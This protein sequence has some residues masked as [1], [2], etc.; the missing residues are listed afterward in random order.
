MRGFMKYI[1]F[2]LTLFAIY[3]AGVKAHS[4]P[5]RL[6]DSDLAVHGT[7]AQDSLKVNYASTKEDA[8]FRSVLLNEIAHSLC[9]TGNDGVELA[10]L[11]I[12]T[13]EI[14]MEAGSTFTFYTSESA[15]T[16]GLIAGRIDKPSEYTLRSGSSLVYIRADVAGVHREVVQLELKLFRQPVI[17]IADTLKMCENSTKRVSAGLGYNSYTWSTGATNVS[18]TTL[19]APGDYWVTVTKDHGDIICSFTKYFTVQ[20]A[21]A[22]TIKSVI[23]KEWE[24]D[25]NSVEV[26]LSKE[27]IGDYEYAIDGIHYQKENVFTGLTLG[28]YTIYVHETKGCG[29]TSEEVYIFN[30]PKYFTPNGD[31]IN[32][33][34]HIKYAAYEPK[35]AVEVYDRNGKLI[36][37][38]ANNESWD[39]TFKGESLPADDYW[40]VIT[41]A[42]GRKYNGHFSLIR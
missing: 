39:G 19:T 13:Q 5:L 16:D 8:N 21:N 2:I 26:V 32:D 24:E 30:Y 3:G 20:V 33:V 14:S 10:D 41:R 25:K 42:D 9:D 22:A 28:V 34:W 31:G 38:F 18:Q 15:A 1:Y 37:K 29:N 11:T 17:A 7:S 4:S 36:T 35:M 6:N 40:F 12:Y 27:S 23:I